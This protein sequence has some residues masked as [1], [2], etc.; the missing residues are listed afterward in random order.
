MPGAP[1]G[2]EYREGSGSGPGPGHG[3]GGGG[4]T[5]LCGG[6]PWHLQSQKHGG[7][8]GHCGWRSAHKLSCEFGKSFQC[9]RTKGGVVV[10]VVVVV[11]V[12]AW[13]VVVVVLVVVV[14]V[15]SLRG[16][17]SSTS[18]VRRR[19]A[20]CTAAM[21]SSLTVAASVMLS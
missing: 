19:N 17:C 12:T 16:G 3:C 4:S 14:V 7:P 9:V 8:I 2:N 1:S 18:R 15:H 5:K 21:R 11:V 13:V 6:K 10:V 20:S